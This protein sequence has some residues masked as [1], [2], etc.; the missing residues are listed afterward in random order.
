MVKRNEPVATDDDDDAL[1]APG[2]WD[3]GPPSARRGSL[4]PGGRSVRPPSEAEAA[5]PSVEPEAIAAAMQVATTGASMRPVAEALL[6][7]VERETDSVS[8]ARL[9]HPSRR[10][11]S[12]SP[13][14]S[15][16]PV[17]PEPA[18][19]APPRAPFSVSRALPLVSLVLSCAGVGFLV[20][21]GPAPKESVAAAAVAAPHREAPARAQPAEALRKAEANA[22]AAKKPVVR[23]E[24]APAVEKPA[25][26]AAPAVE[27][28]APAA[29]AAGM[30][31]VEVDVY[32]R[33]AAVGYLGIMQRGGPPYAFEVPKGN[34]IAIEVARKGYG[35]RKVTLDGSQPRIAIGLRKSAK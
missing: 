21:G 23:T 18:S 27:K 10:P 6:S 35:T 11:P 7:A 22:P 8:G 3:I 17:V 20:F 33:D 4:R 31:R 5:K 26:A 32:P 25:P 2:S 14:A 30:T 28:P 15:V 9:V 24:R 13:S 34:K 1:F 16:H 29:A 12:M 19:K